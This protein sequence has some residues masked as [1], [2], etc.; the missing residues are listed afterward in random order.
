[1]AHYELRIPFDSPADLGR[2]ADAAVVALMEAGVS[3]HGS[4]EGVVVASD[5][6]FVAVEDGEERPLTDLEKAAFDAGLEQGG[7]SDGTIDAE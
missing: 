4:A 2:A 7:P 3:L 1:V 6:W 5:R